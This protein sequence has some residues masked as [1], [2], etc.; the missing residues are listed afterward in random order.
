MHKMGSRGR[1]L[2]APP[3]RPA[4]PCHRLGARTLGPQAPLRSCPDSAFRGRL[5]RARRARALRS[6]ARRAARVAASGARCLGGHRCAW[7]RGCSC[8]EPRA[9]APHQIPG[10]ARLPAPRHR[11]AHGRAA[12]PEAEMLG[13]T[14]RVYTSAPSHSLTTVRPGGSYTGCAV[15]P[16]CGNKSASKWPCA[17]RMRQPSGPRPIPAVG[18]N[19][20]VAVCPPCAL[21]RG[22]CRAC[23]AKGSRARNHVR[24]YRPSRL[25]ILP[26]R[27]KRALLLAGYPDA[28]GP[29][30]E[31]G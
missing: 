8:P 21:P 31:Q 11:R 2:L 17:C 27:H 4:A 20:V 29:L 25:A 6:C 9:G 23:D 12:G 10:P 13:K 1:R 18:Q 28:A 19:V 15:R 24:S 22:A 16:P 14:T 30:A 5:P 7:P 26:R 3:L